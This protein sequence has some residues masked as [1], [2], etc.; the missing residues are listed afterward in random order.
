MA[1]EWLYVLHLNELRRVREPKV[2]GRSTCRLK[3]VC[4]VVRLLLPPFS[5]ILLALVDILLKQVV[6]RLLLL[7]AQIV[8]IQF[9]LK[10]NSLR[11]EI[12]FQTFFISIF[13]ERFAFSRLLVVQLFEDHDAV[14]QL[15]ADLLPGV[16]AGVC[17]ESGWLVLAVF[18][19]GQAFLEEVLQEV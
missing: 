13:V 4:S 1:Q 9:A 15:Y 11:K 18:V 2:L 10:S 14:G 8:N 17:V 19:V 16:V 12:A 6:L 7:F 3:E 5:F